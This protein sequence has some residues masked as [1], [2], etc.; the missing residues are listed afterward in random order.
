VRSQ[1]L[2]TR[3]ERM[4]GT[5]GLPAAANLD[6]HDAC[7][8]NSVYRTVKGLIPKTAS[9]SAWFIPCIKSTYL[10]TKALYKKLEKTKNGNATANITHTN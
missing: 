1:I 7:N 6:L 8:L 3:L 9:V 10:R 5:V 4:D 2:M